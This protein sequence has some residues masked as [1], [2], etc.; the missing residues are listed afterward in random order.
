MCVALAALEAVVLVT[1]PGGER[2]IPIAEFHRLP[3]DSP[4]L[5]TS[6]GPDELITGVRL[7]AEGFPDHY[8]Y[9]KI[10]DRASYAFA[11][12]S[13]AA[14]LEVDDEEHVT[15]VRVAWGGAAH[16]PWRARTVE[17]RLRGGPVDEQRV[18]EAVRAE[19]EAATTSSGTAYKLAMLEGLT[20]RALTRLAGGAR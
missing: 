16:K 9:L 3:G 11:L 20:A 5:D 19:L 10:R 14:A 2:S 8:T 7:P 17:E 6:L 1:G 4:H 18:R 12:V 13:V 15:D